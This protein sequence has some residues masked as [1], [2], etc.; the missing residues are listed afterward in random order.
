MI[1]GVD[2]MHQGNKKKSSFFNPEKAGLNK[3]TDPLDEGEDKEL[4]IEEEK[5][6]ARQ[7]FSIKDLPQI[8]PISKN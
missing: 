4:V 6:T 7:S 3:K 1:L 5:E 8:P 2:L